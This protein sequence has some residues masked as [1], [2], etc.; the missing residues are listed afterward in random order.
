MAIS[1]T[2]AVAGFVIGAVYL[3]VKEITPFYA[4]N[5][6]LAVCTGL[7]VGIA[8]PVT[9]LIEAKMVIKKVLKDYPWVPSYLNCLR[10]KVKTFV[11]TVR[12]K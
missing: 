5:K 4:V 9:A 11:K 7:S 3:P 12:S 10:L 6:Y 1:V 8:I 2:L